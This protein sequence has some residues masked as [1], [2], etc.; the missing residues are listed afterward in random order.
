[1]ARSRETVGERIRARGERGSV[2]GRVPELCLDLSNGTRLRSATMLTGDPQWS[3]RLA[4]STWLFRDAGLF[5]FGTGTGPGT[6][7]EE[8]AIFEYTEITAIRGG[9]A[10]AEPTNGRCE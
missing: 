10:L 6:T 9:T 4:E 3:F 5:K 1:M 2:E 8:N 7:P